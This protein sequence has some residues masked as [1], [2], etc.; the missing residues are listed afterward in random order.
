[1]RDIAMATAAKLL[2]PS[3]GEICVGD[4]ADERLDPRYCFQTCL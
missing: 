3:V 1:M 4:L 2:L